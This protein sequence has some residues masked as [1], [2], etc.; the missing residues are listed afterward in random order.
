MTI[1]LILARADNGVIGS[2]GA[3]PW[4]LPDDMR[5]FK[6]LT[7]GKPCIMG[8][9]TWES[10]PKRPLPGRTN[11]VVTRNAAF[12]AEGAAVAQSF[13]AALAIAR[14][15]NPSEIMVIGG[16]EIYAAALPRAGR[17]H[18]TEI[19][20]VFDGD[21]RMPAFDKKIWR[22]TAREDHAAADGVAY[23]YV[24]LEHILP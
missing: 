19:H 5:R 21:A 17:I 18:L 10:L 12:A 2:K 4:R 24:T 15:E 3:L 23:S 7:M 22:E 20:A 8:R 1:S 14:K 11:I 16:A 9:K 6:A 13:D